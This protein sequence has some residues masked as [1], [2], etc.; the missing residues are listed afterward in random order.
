[1]KLIVIRHTEVPSNL[2]HIISGSSDESL[3]PNG[4][5]QANKLRSDLQRI[6]YDVIFSSP[7]NRAMETAQIIN[8][9][10][11]P[12]VEDERIRDRD[13]GNLLL[14]SR[15]LVN[16]SECNRLDILR[17]KDGTETLLSLIR[18]VK[19]FIEDLKKNYSDKTIVIVTHN[20]ISRVFWLLNNIEKKS[21]KEI[22]SYYHSTGEMQ[23]YED[24]IE[25]GEYY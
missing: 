2:N 20:S 16:K 25:R 17:T 18:R 6:D 21:I 24:F 12:I 19:L 1:M 13:P 23:I 3:T 11:L 4:I 5:I 22:N 10:N 14:K 7:V 8:Y 15:D 9:K